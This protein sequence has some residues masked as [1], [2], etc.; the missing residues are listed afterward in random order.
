MTE[1]N[2]LLK[3]KKGRVKKLTDEQ[4]TLVLEGVRMTLEQVG[5]QRIVGANSIDIIDTKMPENFSYVDEAILALTTGKKTA[6]EIAQFIL[7]K[8]D[9]SF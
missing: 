9:S 4:A 5:A 6:K 2:I 7:E 1:P 3:T 8:R